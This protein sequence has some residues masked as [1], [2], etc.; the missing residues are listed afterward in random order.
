MHFYYGELLY[1]LKKFAEAS[2]E[3]AIIGDQNLKTQFAERASQNLL[4]ALEKSLPTDEELQ[5]KVGNSTQ[6]VALDSYSER[7]IKAANQNLDKYSKSANAGDIR[8]RVGRLYYLTNN[9]NPA[10]KYFR[11]VVALHPRTKIAEY[12]ANLLL[13]IYNLRNDYAGLEQI[14]AELLANPDLANTKTGADIRSVLEKSSF[15]KAQNLEIEKKY[16]ESAQQ[17]QQFY[18]QSPKAELAGVASF[19]AAVNFERAGRDK[20]AIQN[21]NRVLNSNDKLSEKFKS[22]SKRL[23]AKLYQD[24]GQFDQAA[25]VYANLL[26]T[27]PKDPLAANY[28]FN[29]ALMHELSGQNE[30]A[31]REYKRYSEVNRNNEENAAIV[32]KI[33]Q[34][35]R[36]A[37][38]LNEASR[39]YKN[40]VD[41]PSAK[42][43]RK[44]EAMYYVYEIEKQLKRRTDPAT[45]EVKMASLMAKIPADKRGVTNSYL[46]K[47]KLDGAKKV[48]EKLTGIRIPNNPAKQKAAVDSKLEVVNT[49]NQRLAQIIKLDSPEE[50]VSSITLLGDANNH[51]AEA[52][53]NVA[54]PS[55]LSEDNKKLYQQEVQKIIAP[56]ISKSEESYKLAVTRAGEL[57]VYNQ[58]YTHAFAQLN[59]KFPDQYYG[60]GEFTS[61]S[62]KI[63]WMER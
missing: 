23:V 58:D 40:Y 4:L 17:F 7:F 25:R 47:V 32:F 39:E 61:D 42:A 19:N 15:K 53:Q 62:K 6:P 18:T 16:L 54:L 55:N 30:A 12:S 9:F 34:I 63:D 57:Q 38:K 26:K 2:N 48:Y 8:F 33:A 11:D 24:T 1:D 28:Q 41:L 35:R 3:Y 21:Y 13:D 14:G 10:E 29:L 43:D 59:K 45:V 51:M 31:V 60:N 50:I 20:E 37:K 44:V 49:L 5:K 36:E 52:F 27:E 46:A 22:K 56:F